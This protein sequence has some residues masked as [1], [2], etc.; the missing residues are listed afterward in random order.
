[1]AGYTRYLGSHAEPPLRLGADVAGIGCG[2]FAAQAAL[3]ALLHRKSS[4]AVQSVDVS[5][6]GALLAMKT[7]HLAAQSDPE[8]WGG[9]RL[10]GAN[11]PPER[12]WQ[13]AD[14]PIT[15]SFGGS[16]G[17]KGRPGWVQFVEEM[18]LEHL[19]DDE[20]FDK[21]GRDSKT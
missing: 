5:E 13:T 3:A 12:G 20:R 14:R 17:A 16:I 6:L 7:V 19:L 1:M 15:F 2:I 21:T 9:P 8:A 10:G 4:G 18:G 11:D